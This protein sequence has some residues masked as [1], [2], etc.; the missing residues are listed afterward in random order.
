MCPRV[1]WEFYNT[2][3]II[4]RY[5]YSPTQ[6]ASI[7]SPN[8]GCLHTAKYTVCLRKNALNLG[9]CS[10]VEHGPMFIIFGKHNQHTLENGLQTMVSLYVHFYLLSLPPKCSATNYTIYTYLIILF[11][12]LARWSHCFQSFD[13]HCVNRRDITLGSLWLNFWTN[14]GR[15][16]PKEYV[17]AKLRK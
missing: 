15:K 8:H 11:V 4:D 12:F 3:A 14:V 1:R 16:L 6:L 5:H 2:E 7:D 10:F 17:A 13:K 9:S